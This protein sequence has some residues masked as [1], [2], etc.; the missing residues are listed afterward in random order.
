MD[1]GGNIASLL[2]STATV[3]LRDTVENGDVAVAI[4]GQPDLAVTH[5]L[6]LRTTP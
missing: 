2:I 1:Q 4:S 3:R 5:G 6:T